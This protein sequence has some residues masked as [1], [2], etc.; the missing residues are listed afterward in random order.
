MKNPTA[1]S[2]VSIAE[3]DMTQIRHRRM[4]QSG[5]QPEFR[6]DSRFSLRLI[7]PKPV[8]E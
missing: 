6:L 3:Y 5:V 7:R 1:S 8:A 4:S 2:A